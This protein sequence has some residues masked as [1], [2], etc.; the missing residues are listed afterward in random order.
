[1]SSK[2]KKGFSERFFDFMADPEG[3]KSNEIEAELKESGIDPIKLK[4]RMEKIVKKKTRK[5][6]AIRC[7][8]CGSVI[9]RDSKF[10]SGCR[11]KI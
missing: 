7:R 8:N 10:C 6:G 1:M 2:R 5:K 3:L 11:E 4:N 9:F